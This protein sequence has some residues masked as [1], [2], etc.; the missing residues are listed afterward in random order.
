MRRYWAFNILALIAVAC[1]LPASW[2]VSAADQNGPACRVLSF[3]VRYN[4]PN[5]GRNAWPHRKKMVANIFKKYAV[6]VA[7]LQEPDKRQ[8][9]DLKKRLPD[10]A[11][12]GVKNAI[13]YRSARYE[14]LRGGT[15]WLS[16][17]PDRK[18]RGWD[19]QEPRLVRWAELRDRSSGSAWFFF[20]THFDNRGKT[21]RKRSADL[22][23][24][25]IREI[26]RTAPAVLLGDFN[27][28]RT[29]VPYRTLTANGDTPPLLR[30][31]QDISEHPPDGP[32]GTFNGFK[33]NADPKRAIDF[34]FVTGSIDILSHT[35]IA[36][37][38]NGRYPSDHF[39]VLAHV[40]VRDSKKP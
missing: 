9:G 4:T 25:K 2:S 30:D 10:Y 36:D 1:V 14:L 24:R 6:D 33:K 26:A 23:I 18:S 17:T 11:F 28:D 34:I 7:G 32:A 35:V 31:S 3:N 37:S 21:A 29:S 12:Y 19:A 22:A 40:R 13:L 39:P 15:F 16:K 5:D 20:N 8:I 27:C 38:K